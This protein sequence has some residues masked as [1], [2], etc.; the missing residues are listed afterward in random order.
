MPH[1]L[2]SSALS[3]ALAAVTALAIALPESAAA[4]DATPAPA[5]SPLVQEAYPDPA[6]MTNAVTSGAFDF[7]NGLVYGA[8]RTATPAS[9]FVSDL[10]ATR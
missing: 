7:A 9:L 10:R 3:L 8:T 6:L 4:V 1:L 5:P 2:R